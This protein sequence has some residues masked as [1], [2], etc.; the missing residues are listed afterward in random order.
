MDNPR[1]SRGILIAAMSKLTWDGGVWLVPSQSSPRKVYRVDVKAK[2]CDCPDC[3]SGNHCKHLFAAEIVIKREFQPDGS[4]VETTSMTLTETKRKR[5][6]RPEGW[7]AA[8]QHAKQT[9]T[10]RFMVLL[11]ELCKRLLE[12]PGKDTGRP[13]TPMS[14]MAYASVHKVFEDKS[15]LDFQPYLDMAIEKKFLRTTT[16]N[17]VSVC[18]YLQD[19][20]LTPAL[21]QLITYSSLPLRALESEF[22]IDSTGFRTKCFDLDTW[23]IHKHKPDPKD[24]P[25]ENKRT[26]V[27]VHLICGV[28]TH[29]V[30]AAIVTDKDANDSPLL[31]PLL[32]R[33]YQHMDMDEL[34]GDKQYL[35]VKNLEL[36]EDHW[37]TPFMEMKSNSV[38][39]TDCETAWDR[40]YYRY[41][42]QN[43]EFKKH[44]A[45]RVAV[46][47][48][49]AMI[50]GVFGKLLASR[51]PIALMNEVLCK[52]ICANITTLIRSEDLLG[53]D[54]A[55]TPKDEPQAA[56]E[57]GD[58]PQATNT[59]PEELP[60]ERPA[61][62]VYLGNQLLPTEEPP[63]ETTNGDWCNW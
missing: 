49:F 54:P 40:M 51:L 30:T 38:M 21:N 35:S 63:T 36:C 19:P 22:A 43:E 37:I 31:A 44:Y 32:A 26:W 3:E 33:T 17:S 11:H 5:S 57:Q 8:Y 25:P 28:K 60:N 16:M 10:P 27:K 62:R 24:K 52:V 6:P 50:K 53:I 1:Q 42:Y 39:H 61:P 56:P 29:I 20:T 46:E 12:P 7:W 14:D 15:S 2:K 45:N 59:M 58:V 4:V 48:T 9:G 23:L 18:K 55:F 13:R 41:R 34:S 47:R